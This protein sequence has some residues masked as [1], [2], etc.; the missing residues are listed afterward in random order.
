MSIQSNPTKLGKLKSKV[1]QNPTNFLFHFRLII[2]FPVCYNNFA[3]SSTVLTCLF[4]NTC[5]VSS[6]KALS[7]NRP[8]M[9]MNRSR[10]LTFFG[11]IGARLSFIAGP[12]RIRIV[13]SRVC[14]LKYTMT[15]VLTRLSLKRIFFPLAGPSRRVTYEQK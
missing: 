4:I 2:K 1:R 9:S 13:M 6:T 14:Q 12:D 7:N 3:A 8:E 5:S 10:I 15:Y 11:R